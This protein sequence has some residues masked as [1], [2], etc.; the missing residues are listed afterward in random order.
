MLIVQDSA[1]IQSMLVANDVDILNQ[2]SSTYG[3]LP[4]ADGQTA[5]SYWAIPSNKK[6][7]SETLMMISG[8]RPKYKSSPY[9]WAAGWG[10]LHNKHGC[11]I[12]AS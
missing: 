5:R 8:D 9:A 3:D 4:L 6:T 2:G 7:F 12:L 10:R 1:N 11:K